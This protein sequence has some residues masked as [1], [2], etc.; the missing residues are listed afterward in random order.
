M[1]MCGKVCVGVLVLL[2]EIVLLSFNHFIFRSETV[3]HE[4]AFLTQCERSVLG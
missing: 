1:R 3:A 2:T 4:V